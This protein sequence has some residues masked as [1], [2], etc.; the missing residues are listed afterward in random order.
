MRLINADKIY[1]DVMT[2]HGALAISQGQLA[3]AETVNA[4]SIPKGATNGEIIQE[5]FPNIDKAFSNVID[6]NLWWNAPYKA[7]S[8]EEV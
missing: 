1:P 5:L 7:E 4:I 2:Q 8:E 3:Y 6:L